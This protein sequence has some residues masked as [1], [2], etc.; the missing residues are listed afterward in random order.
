MK[1]SSPG[2]MQHVHHLGDIAFSWPAFSGVATGSP[3]QCRLSALTAHTGE[4]ALF[5][6]AIA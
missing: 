3:Q 1:T 2:T 5:L 6:F 4:W